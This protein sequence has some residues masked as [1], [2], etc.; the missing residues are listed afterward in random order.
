MMKL[1]LI[2]N[3]LDLSKLQIEAEQFQSQAKPR[4]KSKKWQRH[5]SHLPQI[6]DTCFQ[7]YPRGATLAPF[8]ERSLS[9][10]D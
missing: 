5:Y 7:D 3:P 8:Q 4:H 9:L 10:V 6:G 2:S 1:K